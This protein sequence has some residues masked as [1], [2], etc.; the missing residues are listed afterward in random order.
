MLK[1]HIHSIETMGLVD[2]PGIRIVIFMMGCKLRCAYCH[3]PDTW[4]CG[5]GEEYTPE[6]LFNKVKR[7]KPYFQSTGGG[8]TVSGGDPL[9]QAEFVTEF[10]K[11]CKADG[12]NTTLDTSGFGYGNYDDLLKVT[13]LILLDIKHEDEDQ[14]KV[15]TGLSR[16]DFHSF[17]DAVKRNGNHMWIRHVV[18]PDLTDG[19]DHIEK[20]AEYINTIPNVDKV[21]LLG[22]H[23]LG[24]SKYKKLGI[25]YRLEGV[26]PL[27]ASTLAKLKN[28][29]NSKLNFPNE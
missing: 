5:G 11:L 13:D 7:Y 28:L 29:M 8:V 22:Y 20:L 16:T 19:E 2:G 26:P 25:P 24:I 21:E 18:V 14:H 15:I 17:L 3:N 10:F 4:K 27:K 1:G 9:L 12:I 23:T 6:A